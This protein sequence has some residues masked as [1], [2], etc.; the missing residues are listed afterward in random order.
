MGAWA[1][2]VAIPAGLTTEEEKLPSPSIFL[3]KDWLYTLQP[4]V[5]E[6]IFKGLTSHM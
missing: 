6:S 3:E 2:H 5:W 1:L 4:A